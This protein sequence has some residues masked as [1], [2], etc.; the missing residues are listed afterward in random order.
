MKSPSLSILSLLS[1]SLV[2]AAANAFAD[3]DDGQVVCVGRSAGQKVR[4][5]VQVSASGARTAQLTL[6]GQAN[7][8][9][10]KDIQ[11]ATIQYRRLNFVFGHH[12]T[13]YKLSADSDVFGGEPENLDER[14]PYRGVFIHQSTNVDFPKI[15]KV[16][17][18]CTK[19]S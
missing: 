7:E 10:F 11:E 5:T 16:R 4:L 6:N 18:T 15:E 3:I 17:M 14:S 1:L 13:V 2:V 9:S 19:S 12:N 8:L